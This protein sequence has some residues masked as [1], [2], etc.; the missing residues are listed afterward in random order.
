[1]EPLT[2][3][4]SSGE[5]SSSS[6]ATSSRRSR[7]SIA[8]RSTARPTVYV[9]LLPPLVA[10]PLQTCAGPERRKR[11]ARRRLVALVDYVA[12]PQIEGIDSESPRQVVDERLD[13][14]RSRRR[15]GGT[16]GA[17]GHPIGG[18]AQRGQLKS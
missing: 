5:I 2:I 17:K 13:G 7:A 16:V 12:Q 8:A 18:D 4:R 9:T 6:A 3:S 1:M 15:R 14:E 11:L 10:H